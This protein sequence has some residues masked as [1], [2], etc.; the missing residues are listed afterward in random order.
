MQDDTL[1]HRVL[2]HLQLQPSDYASNPEAKGAKA[3]GAKRALRDVLGYRLYFDLR[4]G[5][6]ITNPNLEQLGLLSIAYASLNDC[7]RDED[8]WRSRHSLLAAAAPDIRKKLLGDLLDAMR[9]SLCIKT[10]YLD[11]SHL[12]QVR[13]RSYSELKEPWGFAEDERPVVAGVMVPRPKPPIGRLPVPVLHISHRSTYGR[14]IKAKST[15]KTAASGFP[16][17]IDEDGYNSIVDDMLAV[18]CVYGLAEEVGIERG[19]TGYRVPA[20]VIEWRLAP[21]QQ[22]DNSNPFF[23]SLYHNV[24]EQLRGDDRCLH[25]LEAREHTAQVDPD[26]RE[27]REERFRRAS[28]P[29]MF[30]SPTM[31]LG[32]DISM[33]NAVYMRNVPPTPANYAQRSGRAGRSGQPALVITYCAA[34]SPHDQYF[35][36]DPTRMVAGAVNPPSID[37]TNEDLIRSHLYAVWLAETGQKLGPSVQNVLDLQIPDTLPIRGD[38][39]AATDRAVVRQKS[40]QC[41]IS[42]VHMLRHILTAERRLGTEPTGWRQ[43]STRPIGF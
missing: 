21:G 18:L 35:F 22:Q 42:I 37:L 23:L 4:R 41:S 5:W 39:A 12:E 29:V 8:E 33:L 27:V 20:S 3:E 9:R 13:N 10:I 16:H 24:A 26:E 7:A 1:T 30:C 15:W 2:E 36:L 14:R 6:R 34:R 43:R 25:L 17:K 28:L 38:I 11:E 32:V 31:E 40:G 19:L